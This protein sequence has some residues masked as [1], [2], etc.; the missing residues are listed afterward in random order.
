MKRNILDKWTP[1]VK[2]V[3]PAGN[4][5]FHS[6]GDVFEKRI[7]VIITEAFLFSNFY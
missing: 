7:Y 5:M 1:Y 3:V 4:R 6:T 2:L